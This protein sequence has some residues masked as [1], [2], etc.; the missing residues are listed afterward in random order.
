VTIFARSLAAPR[1]SARRAIGVAL[2]SSAIL[3]AF[4][5]SAAA[6]VASV[7]PVTV[8]LQP[9]TNE[10][11]LAEL[12]PGKYENPLGNPVLHG[13]NTYAIY[14]DPTDHYHGD[15]RRVI[16][17]YFQNAGAAS[18]S[19]DN[20][21]AVDSQYTDKSNK[22]AN[23]LQN[24]KGSYTDYAPYPFP[25]SAC[26]DPRP[27]EVAD[28]IGTEVAGK[29][30]AV[31]LTSAQ[32]ASALESFIAQDHLP[33]GLG[34]VYYLLTPPAVTVC[35]DAGGVGGHCSDYV[36]GNKA[37]YEHS[38]CSYHAA[39]NPGGLPTGDANT[40]LYAAIPWSAG[41][42]GDP[43][44]GAADRTAAWECQDGGI[45]PAGKKG[46]YEIE[47]EK[48]RDTKEQE[49]F[50]KKNPEE[51]AAAEEAK[52][53]EGP[54]QQEPNQQGCPTSDGGCDTGLAD[55]IVNQVSLEQQN[56]V[57][58]PLLNAWQDPAR[59]ENTDECR[60]L[61]GSVISGSV[62]GNP[63]TGSGNLANQA[64]GTGSYYLND[65][66]NLA[67]L[68]LPYPG[69]ACLRG[70]NLDPAFTA[71]NPVNSGE[72]IGFDGM[73]SNI[74]LGSAIGYSAGGA[75]QPN[76]ATFS[77]SFGDGTPNV[78]G[79]APGSPPCEAN[80]SSPCAASVFHSYQYGGTY[81]VTLTVTDVAGHTASVTHE[82][83]VSGPLPPSKESGPGAGS[84]STG[85]SSASGSS[86]GGS[87][88]GG[89]SGGGASSQSPV[90]ATAVV[91]RSLKNLGKSG[92]VVRYSVNQQVAG[93]FEVLLGRTL[94]H[95]LG[96]S[97]PAAVGLPPGSAPAVVIAKAILV[98]SAGGRSTVSIQFSK[99][100]AQRLSREHR[101]QLMLRLIVRNA[102]E[103]STTVL[104]TFTLTH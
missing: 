24:F 98:T 47:K 74:S 92:V 46:G 59:G 35:L 11:Y 76:Y 103:R 67:A 90:A 72:V 50:E 6:Q 36:E 64:L 54:H 81:E 66:F 89:S 77:W 94:A 56:T 57:T 95:K 9:R 44:L 69:V 1:R 25:A 40:I 4:A 86:A 33:K 34:T 102:A 62:T 52:K 16:D 21:F 79:F 18:G 55:L 15:W 29:H 12:A 48:V 7:G 80:W 45:N 71:P 10:A 42:L 20:V 14:W 13:T 88:T 61:F 97:G 28:R 43:H 5:A 38:F 51:Q 104:S 99:R 84:S 85:G 27:P 49:E 41:G 8:G 32:L 93:H 91:S 82:V 58:D 101:V 31:C 23:Y 83:S 68:R 30:T 73:E 96:I 78:S 17:G 26:E 63:E 60:F 19:L 87:S 3:L 100:T 37:S 65:A 75:P 2:A 39:I 70:V 53:L 22:P